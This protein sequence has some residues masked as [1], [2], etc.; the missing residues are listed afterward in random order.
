MTP[1]SHVKKE[2]K[3]YLASIG[4]YQFWPVQT[5]FGASTVDCLACINGC[6]FAIEVKRPGTMQATPRQNLTIRQVTAAKGIA[7]ITDSLERVKKFVEDFGTGVDLNP[8]GIHL[9]KREKQIYE[10]LLRNPNGIETDALRDRIYARD[11]DATCQDKTIHVQVHQLNKKLATI[12]KRIVSNGHFGG[13]H[14]SCG[15]YRLVN[16][17][18]P[19]E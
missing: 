3:E 15:E 11:P 12:G 9:S 6:F 16:V 5:G 18:A 17:P 13:K 2:I 7:F 8:E 14:G 4:A 1:E 19:T 10:I